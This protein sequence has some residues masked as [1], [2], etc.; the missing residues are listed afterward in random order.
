MPLKGCVW[1]EPREKDI[2][3]LGSLT[4][5]PQQQN[6]GLG[7]ALLYCAEQWVLEHG[8]TLVQMTVVNV[9][10]KLI[11]WYERRGYRDTGERWEFPY[12]DNRFGTPLRDDLNFVVLEK[13]LVL[14]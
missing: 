10:D 13:K 14:A 8:G 3:Y 11:E 7:Q 6:R 9:R 12:D 2:W 4:V 5:D 1:L